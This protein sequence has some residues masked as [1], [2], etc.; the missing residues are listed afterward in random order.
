MNNNSDLEA[1]LKSVLIRLPISALTAL[2]P[3]TQWALR[4]SPTNHDYDPATVLSELVEVLLR[5]CTGRLGR[6]DVKKRPL[7]QPFTARPFVQASLPSL[8]RCNICRNP[9]EIPAQNCIWYSITVGRKVGY[10]RGWYIQFVLTKDLVAPQKT[11][12]ETREEAQSAFFRALE[13]GAVQVV[14]PDSTVYPPL[15][16]SLGILIP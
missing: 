13:T 15:P 11:L 10:V 3:A 14:N 1:A 7:V 9:I 5:G 4:N 6:P 2:A 8:L 12:H 16:Y